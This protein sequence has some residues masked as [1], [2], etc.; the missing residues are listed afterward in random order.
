MEASIRRIVASDWREMKRVRLAALAADR[1]AF[2]S[3]LEAERAFGD[4]VWIDC[5]R[6]SAT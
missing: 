1:M 2:G 3:T 5:A 6:V 4:D